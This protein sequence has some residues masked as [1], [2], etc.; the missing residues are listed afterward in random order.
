MNDPWSQ[1]CRFVCDPCGVICFSIAYLLLISSNVVVCCPALLGSRLRLCQE[2]TSP[3]PKRGI[4]ERVSAGS[5]TFMRLK[6]DTRVTRKYFTVASPFSDAPLGD[7]DHFFSAVSDHC[8]LFR[9]G[10]VCRCVQDHVH[11][12]FRWNGTTRA[13]LAPERQVTSA[14]K[15]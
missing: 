7:G 8:A 4:R 13:N 14:R 10:H 12:A 3:P 11:V 1:L 5:L 15:T 2:S 9:L 6:R